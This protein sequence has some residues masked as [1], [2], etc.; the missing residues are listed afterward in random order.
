M[1]IKIDELKTG[2][3]ILVSSH[4]WL[5]KQ[6]QKFQKN[7]WNHAGVIIEIWGEIYVCESDKRGICLTTLTDYLNSD[8]ELLICR[9][10]YK[11]DSKKLTEIMPKECGHTRYDYASLVF[12]QLIKQLTGKWI[13]KRGDKAENAYYCSEWAAYVHNQV[14]PTIF[15]NWYEIA[16]KDIFENPMFTHFKIK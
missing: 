8:K 6:I 3:I 16:P 4:S 1:K 7:K 12:F 15:T 11:Y 10:T 9:P 13:G 2:D 14:Y 5:A